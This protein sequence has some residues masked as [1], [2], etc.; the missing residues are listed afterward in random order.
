MKSLNFKRISG[1]FAAVFLLSF[2]FLFFAGGKDVLS[3]QIPTPES[4]FG[5]TPGD[6]R[7][8]FN[9]RDL[10]DYLKKVADISPMM[11]MEEAGVS[12]FG[13]P[14]YVAFVSSAE[15]ISRLEE[16][17][18]IN[19]E[20]ATNGELTPSERKEF[21]DR[22]RVF[23]LFTLSM[24]STE[25]GPSQS[26]PLITYELITSEDPEIAKILDEAVY[27]FVPCHNPDGMDM[28]VENYHSYRDTQYEGASLPG[29][30]HKYVGHNINRD[31][32]T[33]TQSENQAVARIY[34][35]EWYP[36]IMVE[37][38]Q[39][40]STGPRYF[41]SPPH[42]PVAENIQ[43]G[44]WNWMR[45]FGSRA[46]TDMTE[47]GLTGIAVN[48]HF[49]SYWPGATYTALWKGV[50]SMLSEAASVATATPIYVEPGE[51]T[52]SG[53]GLAEYDI[54]INMPAPWP[55][56]WWHLSDIIEYERENTISY[57]RTAALHREEILRF[58][59][60][61]T[62]RE[63]ERG[64]E[65][66]PHYF[67]MPA[68]QHDRSEKARLVN[69]L[70][71]HGV[72][73][74]ELTAEVHL[75]NRRFSPGDIVISLAQ[76]YRAFIKEVMEAQKFPVRHYTRDGDMIRPYDITSW[77]LPLH[78]GVEAVEINT[79]HGITPQ[80]LR[81]VDM[82]YTIT[83]T[84]P[85]EYRAV[86]FPATNNES[87][88]AAFRALG[89][90]LDVKR[91][92]SPLNVKGEMYG[93]GSFYIEYHRRLENVLEGLLVSPVYITEAMNPP[94]SE[95][96]MP[97]IGLVESW[98]HDMDAGW[99]RYVFDTYHIPY[100]V[101]R[102]VDIKDADIQGKFDV[103]VLPDQRTPAIMGTTISRYPPP[104]NEGMEREGKEN[105]VSFIHHGGVVLSWAR[106]TELFLGDLSFE[107]DGEKEN[108]RFPVRNIAGNLSNRGFD[109]T[110]SL[111]KVNLRKDHPVTLG[112]P[113]ETGVFH[114]GNPIFATSLPQ[115]DIDRRVIASFPE[116]GALMSGFAKNED[117]LSRQAALVWLKKGD[118][119]LLLYSF[120]PL[121]RASTGGTYKLL[122]NGLLLGQEL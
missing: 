101:L 42:D 49:D 95:L 24:H 81:V 69:L 7:E 82:P 65:E 53:K 21:I 86:L 60:D 38:H 104:F 116:D 61:H 106:S 39:M 120:S 6:D 103:I 48:Y 79:L 77:S 100:T 105:L 15:N 89:M 97:R 114:R 121:F 50:V 88:K 34:S 43:P 113:P 3:Q 8:L 35:T 94:A 30:Y 17:K 59:N 33:L 27:M 83:E 75:E 76:P 25:V 98:F 52:V 73:V 62:R 107:R 12:E 68:R 23:F 87:Y 122:F 31:F 1:N 117:L 118:G 74:H 85:S 115:F 29:V 64:R 4:H 13:Q 57:L 11:H 36:Q 14:V 37:K 40:G 109:I 84:R 110:G 66:A 70:N 10:I 46:L 45:V 5:F 72:T 71:K 55:G 91:L 102:P 26:A 111:L 80:M 41:V 58:R 99:T 92:S 90:G 20:L 2:S 56:G 119:Q 44:I 67:I 18:N 112:M 19:R 32:V 28:I 63:I 51:L 96:K 22:G 93:K 54:S 78:N 16:L 9:Y 47:A 108:F